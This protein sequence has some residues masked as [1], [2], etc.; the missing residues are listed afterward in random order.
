MFINHHAQL[1][2]VIYVMMMALRV[3]LLY[4]VFSPVVPQTSI[5]NDLGSNPSWFLASSMNRFLTINFL[6]NAYKL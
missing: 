5:Q 2:T 6:M 3:T 1:A 4:L